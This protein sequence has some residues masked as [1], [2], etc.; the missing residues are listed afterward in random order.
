LFVTKAKISN[1][2]Y[3]YLPSKIRDCLKINNCE[4]Y[5]FEKNNK[6]YVMPQ[7]DY[8]KFFASEKEILK[9]ELNEIKNELLM[10]FNIKKKV[11]INPI[12]YDNPT[13]NL[14]I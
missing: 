11:K 7:E 12:L 5:F 2:K 9:S 3:I 8:L 4:L 13:I 6:I 10:L 14:D 1:N